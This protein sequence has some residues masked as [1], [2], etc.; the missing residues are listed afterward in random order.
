MKIEVYGE[1]TVESIGC[2]GTIG[3]G[4]FGKGDV[5]DLRL[6]A[7]LQQESTAKLPNGGNNGSEKV[8]LFYAFFGKTS[9]DATVVIVGRNRQSPRGCRRR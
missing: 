5:W 7:S 4:G 1:N 2:G 6:F 8:Y 9:S 3:I